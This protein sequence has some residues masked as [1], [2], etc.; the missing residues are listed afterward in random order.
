MSISES[1]L[2]PVSARGRLTAA[3]WVLIYG[4]LLAI[5]L[6]LFFVP[7]GASLRIGFLSFGGL[8]L[9]SGIVLIVVRARLSKP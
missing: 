3:I 7:N 5:C 2:P 6:S 1:A 8:A 9:V 4:G